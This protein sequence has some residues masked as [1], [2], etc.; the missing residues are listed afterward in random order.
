MA[1]SRSSLVLLHPMTSSAQIWQDVVPLLSEYHQVFAPTLLGHRGGPSADH[2]PVTFA[3]IVDAAETYLD[4]LGIDQPH[5]AGNSLGG[6]VSIE[7][8]RRGRAQSVCA[9]SP[10]DFWSA[11]D[12]SMRKVFSR[13]RAGAA[14]IRL[15]RPAAPLIL[16]S[17]LGRRLAV[18]G[19]VRHGERLSPE[20]ILDI[21]DD[22]IGCTITKDVLS[23]GAEVEPLDPLPCPVTL[24]WAEGDRLMPTSS[25]GPTAR[26]RLPAAAWVTLPDVGHAAMLDDPALVARTILA[27]T[28][29]QS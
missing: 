17:T 1:S 24:A 7:L 14:L 15:I 19:L 29:A 28:G 4:E 22:S 26:E 21:Y 2:H 27:V 3:D 12:G 13:V 23:S 11:H 5:I 8:A 10:G 16:R 18:Y 6:A 20:R 25:Y 9:I